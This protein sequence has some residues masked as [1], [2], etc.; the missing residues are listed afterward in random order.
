MKIRK[1]AVIASFLAIGILFAASSEKDKKF[2]NNNNQE[3][4]E[5]EGELTRAEVQEVNEEE[6][7]VDV[8]TITDPSKLNKIKKSFQNVKWE[9]NV[10]AEMAR[11]QD[12][13]VTLFYSTDK[14]TPERRYEYRIWFEVKTATIISNKESEGFGS[15]DWENTQNLKNALAN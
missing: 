5:E 12:V 15:L 7:P 9:P 11:E 2:P 6:N 10:Q 3:M 8:V 4:V 1:I 14:N 13:I